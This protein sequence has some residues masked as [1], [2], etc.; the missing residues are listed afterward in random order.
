MKK[1]LKSIFTIV[2]VL[3]ILLLVLTGCGNSTENVAELDMEKIKENL[4]NLKGNGFDIFTAETEVM[5]SGVANFDMLETL[6]DFDFKEFGINPDNISE[7]RFNMDRLNKDLWIVFLP[8]EGMK[9]TVKNET[10]AY[11]QTL[12]SEETDATIK[13]KLENYS[14]EEIEGYLVWVVSEDNARILELTRNAKANILPMMMD[15]TSDMLQDSIGLDPASVTE[16]AIKT[17]ALITSSTTYMVVK[18]ADGKKNE[19]KTALDNYMVALEEQWSTYL[20]EQYELVKNRMFKEYGDY[21]IYIVSE[22]NDLIYDTI[23]SSTK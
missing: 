5:S 14:F 4:D 19:V 1:S 3:S 22:N 13:Q 6:Y 8:V 17:P 12:I 11:I 2:L 18:P 20:P 7:Y 9:D 15:I 16:F 10:D 21:L 23:I